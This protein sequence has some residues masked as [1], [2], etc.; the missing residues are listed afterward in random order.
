MRA[1]KYAFTGLLLAAG[2]TS[3]MAQNGDDIIRRHIDAIGGEDNWSKIVTMKAVGTLSVQGMEISM[4]QTTVHNRAMRTDFSV[5]GSDGYMIVTSTDGWMYMPMQGVTKAT[6]LPEEQLKTMREKLSV[7]SAMLADKKLVSKAEYA[8]KD[9]ID[10][11]ECYKVKVTDKDGNLQTAYFDASTYYLVRMEGTAKGEGGEQEVNVNFSD[12]KKLP[13]GVVMAMKVGSAQGD[14][15]FKTVEVNKT[16]DENIF[17][18][19]KEEME[20]KK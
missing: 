10:K 15:I 8:G 17:K 3:A 13:E 9:T 18:P 1:I 14:I 12:F 5:M 7:R 11:A 19:T 16:I 2:M 20:G 6:P 4:T